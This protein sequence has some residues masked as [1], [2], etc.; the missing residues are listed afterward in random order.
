VSLAFLEAALQRSLGDPELRIAA[1]SAVGGGCIHQTARLSTSAGE[2]FAKWN[3]RCPPDLF[4]GEAAGLEA[5]RAAGSTVVIPRVVAVSAAVAGDPAF[6]VLEYLPPAARSGPEVEEQLGRGLAAIHRCGAG[7]FGF[8]APTYCGATPQ[9]NRES[10]SWSEFYGERRLRSLVAALDK[11]GRLTPGDRRLYE[12]L[13]GRLPGILP[14]ESA[15]SLVHGDLWSGNVLATARGPALVDPACA[16]ADREMEFGITTLFGGLSARAW[17][18]YEEAWP[19][20]AGWRE[21]NP[22]YQLYHLLN[23]ALLFGG[24]YADEARRAARRY[25]G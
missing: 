5:L 21:R 16:Y 2:F 18:A 10:G 13:I 11:E 17:A 23:H 24:H 12:R 6:L 8:P 15:P 7:L 9:D 4:P 14:R 3:A 1:A 19:L 20:P 25:A 22:L